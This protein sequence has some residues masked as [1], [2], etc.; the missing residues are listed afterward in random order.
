MAKKY[1]K[2]IGLTTFGFNVQDDRNNRIDLHNITGQN[3]I[4]LINNYGNSQLN[5][6]FKNESDVTVFSFDMLEKEIVNNEIGQEKYTVL[7]ARVKTGEYGLESE[8]VNSDTG[9]VSYN[10]NSR[11]AEVMPFGFAIFVPSGNVNNGII[12][13]QSIGR[14]SMKIALHKRLDAYI[15]EQSEELRVNMKVIVPRVVL[16]RL[17][18]DGII[19]AIKLIR[20][21]I[22]EDLAERY[23]VNYGVNEIVEERIIRNPIGFIHNKAIEINEWRNGIRKYDD[24]IQ[25]DDFKYD[26]LKMEFKFGKSTKTISL[27]NTDNLQICEDVTNDVQIIGGHPE[28]K[29]LKNIMKSTGEFYMEAKGIL[30]KG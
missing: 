29:S 14:N 8:I 2:K 1:V 26:D 22:P 12:I 15:K 23:G 16:D 27:K 10:K 19:K 20:Y 6:F 30:M 17:F 25:I 9:S 3:F 24:V 21:S 5:K 7:Y 13:L 18:K 28:F 11:E 4:D